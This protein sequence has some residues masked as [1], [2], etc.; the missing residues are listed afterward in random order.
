MKSEPLSM[1]SEYP[2]E[3]PVRCRG[4][5]GKNKLLVSSMI[6]LLS[7]M[8]RGALAESWEDASI[9]ANRPSLL[10]VTVI[11]GTRHHG[12]HDVILE[13]LDLSRIWKDCQDRRL[14]RP[15]DHTQSIATQAKR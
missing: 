1:I 8:M 11:S 12:F 10:A 3:S 4:A 14:I 7:I 6:V 13:Q 5:T 2:E 15:R 9:V